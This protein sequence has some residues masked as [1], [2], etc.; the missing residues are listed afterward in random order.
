M[1]LLRKAWR[2][3]PV[4]AILLTL[5]AGKVS[6]A[7]THTVLLRCSGSGFAGNRQ[8]KDHS[9]ALQ[10]QRD[11]PDTD[12]RRWTV[13]ELKKQEGF[14]LEAAF[15]RLDI[16]EVSGSGKGYILTAG[17]EEAAQTLTARSGAELW[18]VT[19]TIRD[20]IE[21][22]PLQ[23]ELLV[24]K[25]QQKKNQWI[26]IREDSAIL[27]L[28]FSVEGKLP[29]F[30]P[31]R[32]EEE[33]LLDSALCYLEADHPVLRRYQEETGTLMVSEWPLGVPYYFGGV[34]EEKI[35]HRFFPR[36]VTNYYR[37]DRMYL[38]GLDCSGFINLA[39]RNSGM[40]PIAISDLLKEKK[41]SLLLNRRHPRYWPMFLRPGD[42]IAMKHGKFNHI[43]M[44]LG[45]LRTFGWNETNVGNALPV[46]DMP[47]VIHCGENPFYYLRYLDYIREQGYENT[48]PPD[49]G[50]T[51]SV[52][53]P[54]TE[55]APYHGKSD[56]GDSFS[57]Y[58]LEGYPLLVFPLDE[59]SDLS[60][61][62]VREYRR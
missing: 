1:R 16:Q 53:Q 43:V 10:P 38:C 37:A 17:D 14:R 26:R 47:L 5:W 52:I 28:T 6:A 59:C 45:T 8:G 30:L 48:Y 31:D 56:W 2:I 50:V 3:L 46:L 60:W 25:A 33:T 15:L 19:E 11:F 51:V 12:G 42:L 29:V 20:W 62:P 35:L 34:N 57:W 13:A 61:H 54:G 4:L 41:A 9:V 55:D 58:K 24:S 36:Q 23:K 40:G 39:L 21:T 32:V 7:E 22:D 27:Q 49:G 18:E 44:Y